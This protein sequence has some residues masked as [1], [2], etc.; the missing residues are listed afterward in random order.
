MEHFFGK[1]AKMQQL[2]SALLKERAPHSAFHILARN[3]FSIEIHRAPSN[4]LPPE[5]KNMKMYRER[6]NMLLLPVVVP[7]LESGGFKNRAPK[8]VAWHRRA[9][10]LCTNSSLCLPN[11]SIENK[12]ENHKMK[13]VIDYLKQWFFTFANSFPNFCRTSFFFQQNRN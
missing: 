3:W 9:C 6:T 13:T 8:C 4:N 10:S 5:K 12:I 1:A 11:F 7:D 2:R